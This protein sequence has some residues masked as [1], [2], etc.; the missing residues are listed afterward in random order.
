[1]NIPKLV[2]YETYKWK[3]ALKTLYT[4][5]HTRDSYAARLPFAPG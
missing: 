5:C 3:I 2:S 1:M 4:R